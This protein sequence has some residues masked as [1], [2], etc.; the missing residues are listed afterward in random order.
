MYNTSRYATVAGTWSPLLLRAS[1]PQSGV[2]MTVK[3]RTLQSARRR[4]AHGSSAKSSVTLA[5]TWVTAMIAAAVLASPRPASAQTTSLL[6]PFGGGPDGSVPR[7]A[8]IQAGDGNLYG[9]TSTGGPFD[10]GT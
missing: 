8:L 5:L 2:T 6:H 1:F 9:T 7:S 4:F 3:T 10:L